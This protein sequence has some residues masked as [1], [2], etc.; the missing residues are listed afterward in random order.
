MTSKKLTMWRLLW[1]V[2]ASPWFL[3]C[4]IISFR[5]LSA[6][7]PEVRLKRANPS[8]RQRPMSLDLNLSRSVLSRKRPIYIYIYI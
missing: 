5:F 8:S 3:K 6:C 4:F 2:I 1:M 7:G